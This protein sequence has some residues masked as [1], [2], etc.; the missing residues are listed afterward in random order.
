MAASLSPA[1]IAV[2]SALRDCGRMTE[3]EI[4]RVTGKEL[5]RG[6]AGTMNALY[7]ARLV[8]AKDYV[9]AYAI[10]QIGRSALARQVVKDVSTAQ[11]VR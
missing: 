2:L 4:A 10:T 11:S 5:R 1:Q 3:R 8:E 7:R 6:L 9:R